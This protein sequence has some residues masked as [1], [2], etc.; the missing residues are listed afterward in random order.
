[1]DLEKNRRHREAEEARVGACKSGRKK[2]IRVK[3]RGEEINW[4]NNS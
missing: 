4:E 3:E 1:M 2:E